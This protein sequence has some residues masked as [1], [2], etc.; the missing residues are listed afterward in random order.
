MTHHPDTHDDQQLDLFGGTS[1]TSGSG[2]RGQDRPHTGP[3]GRSGTR[4]ESNDVDLMHTVAANAV[5]CG[6][7]IVGTNERV[8]TRV[9]EAGDEVARVPRFEEDAVHQLLRRR[10]LTLGAPHRITCGAASLI[11]TTVLVPKD[12]RARIAR[13]THL[14]RP[15]SWPD[16]HRQQRS[17]PPGTPPPHTPAPGEPVCALC[18]GTGRVPDS[19]QARWTPERGAHRPDTTSPCHWCAPRPSPP[20]RPR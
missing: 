10:W 15:P 6:Y 12:T 16:Q 11:G 9:T 14:Q 19:R 18:R 4:G 13:W 2:T 7:L 8:Y 17:P 1:H 20:R 3:T 5:R